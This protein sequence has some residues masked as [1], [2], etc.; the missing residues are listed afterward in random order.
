MHICIYIY[1]YTHIYAYIHCIRPQHTNTSCELL[2]A[3]GL[4]TV[5]LTVRL[6]RCVCTCVRACGVCYVILRTRGCLSC[7][8]KTVYRRRGKFFVCVG[9]GL[10]MYTPW[11]ILTIISLRNWAISTWAAHV[12]TETNRLHEHTVKKTVFIRWPEWLVH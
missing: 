12:W 3:S 4:G 6:M 1:I 9:G 2:D 5:Q 7:W 10:Q 8:L 11:P